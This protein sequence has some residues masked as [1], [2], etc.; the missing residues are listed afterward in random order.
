MTQ[1]IIV[2]K[3]GSLKEQKIKD[4]NREQLYKKA[5][6][7]KSD[8]FLLRVKWKIKGRTIE[9]WA[10]DSGKANFENKYDFPPPIDSTLYFGNCILID[11]ELNDLTIDDW[12]IMYEKL[13]GGFEDLSATVDEDENEIDELDKIPDSKKT[14]Q[15]YL[16]DG[17][18]VDT[19]SEDE[20][21]NEKTESEIDGDSETEE[22]E[23]LILLSD[24]DD[25]D[26]EEGIVQ[27]DC[28]EKEVY[29]YSSEDE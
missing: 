19:N 10:K 29:I 3:N 7:R 28:L 12:N 24:D 15:G 5:N 4:C 21:I 13:F 11:S 27:N 8:G 16:K 2:E 22:D 6:F 17:F 23:E 26:D 18:V 1:V 14:K 9:L 20:I 25:D